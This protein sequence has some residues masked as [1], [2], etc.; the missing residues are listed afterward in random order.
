[1]VDNTQIEISTNLKEIL[2][3]QATEKNT[4]IDNIIKLALYENQQL[5]KKPDNYYDTSKVSSKAN[6]DKDGNIKSYSFSTAIPK[7]V[8]NKLGL[9]K[10][11]LLYWDID[12]YK[13]IITPEVNATPTPEEASINAGNEIL[14]DMLFNG[15]SDYYTGP[16]SLIK[17][18]LNNEK[19]ELKTNE[20]KIEYL[21]NYYNDILGDRRQG[22]IKYNQNGF[23]QVVLYLLD[24]PLNLPNQYEILSQ[25][26]EEI[27]KD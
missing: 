18:V 22:I 17:K 14:N 27:T 3:K 26:Y 9:T 7:P 15:K 8:L 4:D 21:V 11:Q 1:M 24:Y 10:G 2:Q 5:K 20:D 13:I 19:P 6:K 25:V 16:V 23:K 12:D